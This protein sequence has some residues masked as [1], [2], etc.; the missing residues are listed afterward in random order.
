MERMGMKQDQP[1]PAG[2]DCVCCETIGTSHVQEGTVCQDKTHMLRENGVIAFALADGAGSARLSHFG[3]ETVTERVCGL[4]CG[5]FERLYAMTSPEEA[6]SYIVGEL[7]MALEQTA[8]T[9]GCQLRDLA[10]TL[11]A[12]AVCDV[13]YII[14]HIGD[15][16][17]GYVKDGTLR[18]ASAP[19]NGEFA[20]T[21]VF[22]T[23]EGAVRDMRIRKGASRE[24]EGFVLMSDGSE[25]SLFSKKQMCLAPVLTRLIQRLSVTSAEFLKPKIQQSLDEVVSRKTRDDCSLILAA[26]MERTYAQMGEEELDT[27]FGLGEELEPSE[28]EL[29]RKRYVE[30]LNCLQ[31]ETSLEG[32]SSCLGLEK[33]ETLQQWL[34]NLL[35]MGYLVETETGMLRRVVGRP[36]EQEDLI[37]E[38]GEENV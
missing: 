33:Q 28:R 32:L 7:L 37:E 36:N 27:Y 22:V 24:I 8:G 12:V 11:L 6:K 18:V 4:L 31:R 30:I 21:T 20:N 1:A 25:A 5:E 10:S 9:H 29:R 35:E 38:K 17:I 15:G 19:S 14:M 16:V 23:T 2:W 26:K 34:R 3:A 13:R